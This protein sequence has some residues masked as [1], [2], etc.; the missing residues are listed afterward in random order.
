MRDVSA[1]VVTLNALPYIEQCLESVRGCETIVVDHGSTDGTLQTIR[2]RFPDVRVVEQENRGLAA[3]WNR[4]MR[5]ASGRYFLILNA[6]AWLSDGA[7]AQLVEFAET[8][9]DAAVV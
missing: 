4:G 9:R 6:D 5:E 8:Q 3:G 1:I 7:L 2:E